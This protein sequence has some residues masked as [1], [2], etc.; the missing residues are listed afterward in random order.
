MHVKHGG[1]T[2]AA[3]SLDCGVPQ[4]SVLGPLLFSLYT[5]DIGQIFDVHGLQYHL[6]AD[7][8]QIY[9]HCSP[10]QTAELSIKMSA[11]VEDVGRWMFENRLQLNPDKSEVLWCSSKR[12]LHRTPVDALKIFDSYIKP[13]TKLK[14]LGIYIDSDLSMRSQINS[15]IRT[16]FAMLRQIRSVSGALPAVGRKALVSALIMPRIDYGNST[17][18]GLPKKHLSRI[19]S[20]IN[21]AAKIIFNSKKYDHVT[22]LLQELHWL[23]LSER[24]E[25]KV[26]LLVFK[27]L[28]G[29]CPT[30]LIRCLQPISAIQ[31]RQRLRS[32]STKD[33]LVPASRCR[34]LG[35][36][37]FS[38]IGPK[39]WNSL[40]PTL[41]AA[42]SETEFR[43]L[44]KTFFF[45]KSY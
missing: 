9:G 41:Q 2:S 8:T 37:G 4:G 24:I 25:F 29:N 16:C 39:V 14:N 5:G 44:L 34:T 43:S 28:H 19:Q 35:D 42:A 33:L 30:Y 22:P 45:S 40:P 20:I 32:S 36:R 15:I 26:A 21:T 17:L 12:I 27:C 23:R 38:V 18:A 31:G 13:T 1:L 3:A 6:Y 10:D 11:C 7:D